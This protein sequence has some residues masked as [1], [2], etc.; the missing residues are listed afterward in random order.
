MEQLHIDLKNHITEGEKILVG[1]GEEWTFTGEKSGVMEGYES[2]ARLLEGKDYFIVTTVTDGQISKSSLDASRITAPCGNT[3]WRQCSK[4]CTKDIWEEGEIP[5]DICPHCKAPMTGN[6]V[7]A[8]EYIEEGYLPQWNR[9]KTW[10]AATLN[11][12][13]I[14][15]EL[16]VDF[17]YPTVIRWPFEKTVYVNHKAW[18]YRINASFAQAASEIGQRMTLAETNSVDFIRSFHGLDIV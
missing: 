8:Q 5:E 7:K 1:L 9:Y 3:T 4:S 13:L 15:L 17:Q 18:M 6:T 16:G 11:R 10:L 12:R 14:V 2:L